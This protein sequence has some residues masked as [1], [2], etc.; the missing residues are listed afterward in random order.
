MWNNFNNWNGSGCYSE[1]TGVRK[2]V[3]ALIGAFGI[4]TG[5]L[6]IVLSGT[7]VLTAIP[8]ISNPL[9]SFG[10]AITV[11][12]SIV[13]LVDLGDIFFGNLLN[14][15]GYNNYNNF[16]NGMNVPMLGGGFG[17]DGFGGMGYGRS[18]WF[19]GFNRFFNRGYG[20]DGYDGYGFDGLDRSFDRGYRGYGGERYAR[21]PR[22]SKRTEQELDID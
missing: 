3:Y 9:R 4:L 15:N 17:F 21:G 22:V 14:G 8:E 5:I 19:G 16:N 6:F 7:T 18:G 20:F 1:A 10:I 12:A 11:I 13:A 2:F